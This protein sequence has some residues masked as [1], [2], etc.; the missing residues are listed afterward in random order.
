MSTPQPIPSSL[1]QL[2]EQAQRG[3]IDRVG[4]TEP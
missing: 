2:T 4:L 3:Q 1:V